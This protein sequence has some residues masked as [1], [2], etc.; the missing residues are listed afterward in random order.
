MEIKFTW[1]Y[2]SGIEKLDLA[3]KVKDKVSRCEARLWEY[4]NKE[5][6]DP[7]DVRGDL[8]ILIEHKLKARFSGVVKNEVV[9]LGNL[10]RL[11]RQKNFSTSLPSKKS[12]R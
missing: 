6:G 7:E 4:C 8:R 12:K 9:Q 1:E 5:K 10:I 3:A 11:L 2:G